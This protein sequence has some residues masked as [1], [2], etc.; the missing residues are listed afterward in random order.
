MQPF[1]SYGEATRVVSRIALDTFLRLSL[2]L[3][4][5]YTANTG[6]ADTVERT[7]GVPEEWTRVTALVSS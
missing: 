4:L 1:L 2:Q 6:G 5:R 3:T 7:T